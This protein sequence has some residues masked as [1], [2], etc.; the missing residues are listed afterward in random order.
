MVKPATRWQDAL[1]SGNGSIGAM[2]YGSI[3]NETILFNHEE[4]WHEGSEMILPNISNNLSGLREL[5]EKKRYFEADSFLSEKFKDLGYEPSMPYYHPAFDMKVEMKSENEFELYKRTLS[6]DTGEIVV[7]WKDGATTFE[8]KLFVSKADNV[9]VYSIQAS[10]LEK[11]NCDIHL[12]PHDLNDSFDFNGNNIDSQIR[13]SQ[14]VT[15]TFTTIIGT[16]KTGGEFGGTAYVVTDGGKVSSNNKKLNIT[17]AN[18]VLILISLFAN[19]ESTEA[20]KEMM[21]NLLGLPADYNTLYERHVVIHKNIFTRMSFK[22]ENTT[23]ET[24]NEQLLLDVY[25]GNI[26]NELIEKLFNFGRYLII[27]S[28]SENSLPANL[29]GIWNGNYFPAW[30][31]AFFN[32]INIEMNY[33]QALPG[34]IAEVTECFFTYYESLLDDFRENATKLF[35]CRGINVPLYTSPNKGIIRDL[36]SQCIH[37]TGGAAWIAQLFYDYYLFTE[38]TDFLKD[39][40]IP[41]MKE[42]ALFYEDFLFEG[43][44]GFFVSAPSNSPENTP[45]EYWTDKEFNNPIIKIAIN[46]TMDFAMIKEVLNNLCHACELL[47]MDKDNVF[48]WKGMLKK[49]KAYEINEDGALKEWIHPDFADNYHHRHHSHMYPLFPGIEITEESDLENFE[50]CR[51]AIDKRLQVGL[52]QQSGWSFSLMANEYARL[53]EGDKALKSIELLTRSCIV[54]N[55][56]NCHSDS[57]NQGISEKFIW[58]REAPFQIDANLGLTAAI[59]EMLVFST[60]SMIKILPA[61]PQKWPKGKATGILCRGCIEV[62]IAWDMEE[63]RII[64]EFLSQS[65][66]CITVKFP[67]PIYKINYDNEQVVIIECLYGPQYREINLKSQTKVTID[68]EL[69]HGY[70]TTT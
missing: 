52:V 2:V 44:D 46:S 50:A 49:I 13:F 8:R 6:C 32:N 24:P 12:A 45:P 16:Y 51:I 34:N 55:L 17:N 48:K 38:N 64:V 3:C 56:F 22:L 69:D 33:W 42:T 31:S 20:L 18:K 40:A 65:S 23:C 28:S 54:D 5:L 26:S 35:G 1:P 7:S 27:S 47:D 57:R 30:C 37:W 4:L 68:V 70:K 60:P 29:Q 62:S 39:R 36:Q 15:N 58:G 61:L 59:L 66:K 53:G 9:V 14:S 67:A 10:N 19:N 63:H 41:F 21:K 11:I 25:Q 43:K